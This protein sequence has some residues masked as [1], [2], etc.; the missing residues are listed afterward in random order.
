M[1]TCYTVAL[2]M[3]AGIGLG[4]AAV[5]GVSA[6]GK[7][8]EAYVVVDVSAI[9]DAEMYKQVGP[10]AGP[11]TASTGGHFIARTENITAL[12]GSAPKQ[13]VIIAFDSIEK[14]K[15][16]DVL[17]EKEIAPIADKASTQRRFIV[18]GM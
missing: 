1:N 9:T 15:A 3:L 13:F 11:I 10:K 7:A 4:A 6:Q 17:G 12:H 8:P 14:A 5:N 16:W 2:A 18:E